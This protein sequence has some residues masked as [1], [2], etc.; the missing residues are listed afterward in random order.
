VGYPSGESARDLE[1][2]MHPHPTLTET[3][4]K[5]AEPLRGSATLY[6]KPPQK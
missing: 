6:Y 3:I 2:S 1:M 4:M 5:D